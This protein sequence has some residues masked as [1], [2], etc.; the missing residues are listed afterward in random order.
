MSFVLIEM[1]ILC[2][3]GMKEHAED[4]ITNI[5][6]RIVG[7]IVDGFHNYFHMEYPL[8]LLYGCNIFLFFQF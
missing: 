5:G 3:V 2:L 4:F 1:L 7:E 6:I 8:L